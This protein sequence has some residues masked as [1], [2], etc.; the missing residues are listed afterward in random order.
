VGTVR[1]VVVDVRA[2]RTFDLARACDQEP[3]E[4]LAADGADETLGDGVLLRRAERRPNDLESFGSED[5]VE[6]TGELTVPIVDEESQRHPAL[7]Q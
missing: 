6:V 7:L 3:V 4:A 2:E 5:L 1:V